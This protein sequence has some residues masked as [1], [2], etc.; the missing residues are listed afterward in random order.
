V[1]AT[2][3]N[4]C[5]LRIA[6]H[7]YC[8]HPFQVQLGRAL[9]LRGHEVLHLHCPSVVSGK[10]PVQRRSA[11]PECFA[12]DEVALDETFEKYA[13][14]RRVAQE[15][16][17]GARLVARLEA[18]GP[19]VVL[20]SNTPLLAQARLV[21]W[22]R[23]R[24]IG[25]V[26]WQQD[27]LS[28]GT[29]LVLS[30]RRPVVGRVVGAALRRVERHALNGS[31]AVVAIT[32]DFLPSLRA[33]G[34][35]DAKV[36]VIENWA[37][38]EDLPVVSRDNAWRREAGL[39]DDLVFLYSGT[40]GLKHDPALLATLAEH[41]AGRARVVVVSEGIGA[42]WLRRESERRGLTN[43]DVR[44]FEPWER[45]PEVLG[46]ADVLVAVLEADAG[47]FSVPSK[48]LSYLC[49]GRP[50]L[51]AVPAANLASRLLER[52]G[53]GLQ[54]EPGDTEGFLR[55]ADG[56][57]ASAALRAGLGEAARA[58]AERWFDIDAI[59]GRFEDVLVRAAQARGRDGAV[60]TR[61]RR[62]A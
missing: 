38:L 45:L 40:L 33:L 57:V 12:V 29:G 35:A 56:L 34:V 21:R 37:P 51:A 44:P 61:Q 32:G 55:A 24:G 2:H 15:L 18:F 6:V 27:V 30:R 49:A 5:S 58:A 10:G 22:C 46:A 59:A 48:V 54:V 8:G 17:Y 14:R 41:L 11:D 4:A 53:A 13:A 39:G 47:V 36:T 52:A 28:A 3:V 9:A 1:E 60:P 20:S 31:D 43:L 26:F 42:D 23:A 7:D 62:A 19:D 16:T 25:S 50:V